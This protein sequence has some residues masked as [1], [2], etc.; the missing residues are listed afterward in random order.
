[1]A[2]KVTLPINV[3]PLKAEQELKRILACGGEYSRKTRRG[4]VCIHR[5]LMFKQEDNKLYSYQVDKDMWVEI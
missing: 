1:M 4:F 5:G 2:N 3:K